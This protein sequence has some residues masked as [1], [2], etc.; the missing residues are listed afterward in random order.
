MKIAVVTPYYREDPAILEQCHRSVA[1][2]RAACTHVMVADGWPSAAVK[3]WAVDHVVL[4]RCHHDIG[5][6]PRVIGSF[7]AIGLGFDGIAFL[8]ADNWYDCDHIASL[9]ELHART[10][11]PFLTSSRL[12]C[13]LDGSVMGKCHLTNAT[14]FV[15]T[16]C[17][18]LMHGAFGLIANWSLMPDYAQIISDRVFLSLARAAG[19]A[20]AHSDRP[21]VHYR[22]GKSGIY[23]HFGE[24]PPP[25]VEPRPDYEGALRHW[26]AAGN[27]ALLTS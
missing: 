25:G 5:S 2:Q 17:M 15:D 10:G 11:A 6:T 7:H 8:D 16:S 20:L 4:P 26:H 24:T 3:T 1:G 23:D 19:I 14:S 21:T 18:L 27:P 22:C 13:R 12:L 9:L